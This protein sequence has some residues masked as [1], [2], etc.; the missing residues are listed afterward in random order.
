MFGPQLPPSQGV[1]KGIKKYF[2][3]MYVTIKGFQ[4]KIYYAP[5]TVEPYF[6]GIDHISILQIRLVRVTDIP[7][8]VKKYILY[9]Y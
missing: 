6:K 8:Y 4:N 1:A 2:T 3:Y 7:S 5:S 9:G